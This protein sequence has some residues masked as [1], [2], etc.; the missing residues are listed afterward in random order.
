MA[1]FAGIAPAPSAAPSGTDDTG[2]APA[3]GP[4]VTGRLAKGR[5]SV[6][7][8]AAHDDE[9]TWA[10]SEVPGQAVGSDPAV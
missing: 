10:A 3:P 6:T 9:A 5:E 7:S 8:A 2:S 1:G 4:S